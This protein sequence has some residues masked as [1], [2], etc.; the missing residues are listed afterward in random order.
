MEGIDHDDLKEL[1]CGVLCHPVGVQ[2]TE[3]LALTSSTFLV[4]KNS[5]RQ[6]SLNIIQSIQT[7]HS[8]FNGSIH[9]QLSTGPLFLDSNNIIQSQGSLFTREAIENDEKEGKLYTVCRISI[10]L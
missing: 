7:L 2:D 6:K 10:Q 5:F 1:V 8:H 9:T 4:R 3:S